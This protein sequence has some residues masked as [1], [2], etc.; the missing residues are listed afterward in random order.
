MENLKKNFV[1][2]VRSIY[3]RDFIPLHRP[4]FTQSE[5]EK[6]LEC[7]DTNF[8]SSV[9]EHVNEFENKFARFVDS[10]Y[11]VSTVNGTSAL[12]IA[13]LIAGV[14]ANDEVI[15]QALSFVATANAISY[16]NAHPIF[17]DVDQTTMGMCPNALNDF[18]SKNCRRIDK[19]TINIK[20]GRI[21]KACVPMHTFGF[22]CQ[23]KE[24]VEVCAEWG[25]V[26]IEDAAESLGS[27]VGNVHT[28]NFGKMGTFSFNGNKIITTGG[29]GMLVTNCE[30]VARRAKHL[31]T[32]AKISHPFEFIHDE[33]GYNYRLPS[34]NAALG[35]AQLDQLPVFLEKKSEIAS[36]YKEFFATSSEIEIKLP[37]SGTVP[38]YW[39]N[40]LILRDKKEKDEWLSFTNQQ[41]IMT[42]PAW[43]LLPKLDMFKKCQT[44]SLDNSLW[45]SQR[46][47]NIPSS[48]P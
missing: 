4:V 37:L 17:I 42:R 41:K 7:I 45:L 39:L 43:Q 25:I 19:T 5:K 14:E 40:T 11:A 28:G 26:V 30:Q 34:I 21:I 1:E 29:G 13:L 10:N 23:I 8:V 35:L 36:V 48:V 46:I 33:V 3:G 38:N 27:Y 20:T 22:P 24:I 16:T 32:T 44:D 9:G 47:L 15:T 18:L 6:V 31:T 2:L 12:H